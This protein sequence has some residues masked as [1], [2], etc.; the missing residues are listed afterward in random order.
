MF[1]IIPENTFLIYFSIHHIQREFSCDIFPKI[2]SIYSPEAHWMAAGGLMF[3]EQKEIF[4]L[5]MMFNEAMQH[6][7]RKFFLCTIFK[8]LFLMLYQKNLC[9][10]VRCSL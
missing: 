2:F 5:A 8:S 3:A 9:V 1:Q 10:H 6:L 7:L 4:M